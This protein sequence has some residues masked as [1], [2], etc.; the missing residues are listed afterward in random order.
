MYTL[1]I[2]SFLKVG[3]VNYCTYF[4]MSYV[5]TRLTINVKIIV[6]CIILFCSLFLIIESNW[7]WRGQ[8][9]RHEIR[10]QNH[11][12]MIN[13]GKSEKRNYS[14]FFLIQY[15][16]MIWN[17]VR[18]L[19][20]NYAGDCF[21][22]LK[23]VVNGEFIDIKYVR[24]WGGKRKKKEG[25]MISIPVNTVVWGRSEAFRELRRLCYCSWWMKSTECEHILKEQS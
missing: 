14:S 16:G 25:K 22:T 17:R 13:A 24:F 9:C 10:Q 7:K 4:F 1:G 20:W 23:T 12:W 6:A 11:L 2:L 3:H 19:V 21:Y 18:W 8:T 15:L 5:K